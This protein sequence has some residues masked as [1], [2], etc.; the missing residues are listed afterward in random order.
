[1]LGSDYS[2]T[3]LP[4]TTDISNIL[5]CLLPMVLILLPF[6]RLFIHHS[7][8]TRKGERGKEQ[9]KGYSPPPL[10]PPENER[11]REMFWKVFWKTVW[12][13]FVEEGVWVG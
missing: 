5:S 10:L 7:T 13:K 2:V 1:M 8:V 12:K 9:N 4:Y 11:F 3:K 6:P